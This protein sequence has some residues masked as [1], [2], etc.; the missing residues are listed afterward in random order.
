MATATKTNI[1]QIGSV[2]VPVSDPDKAIEFY[3]GK[4]GCE[5]RADVPFGD[6]YR[7]IEVAPA[8]AATSI[9]LC[10]PREGDS[11]GVQTGI[12]LTTADIDADHAVLKAKGV[13]I[14]DEVSRMGDPVPPLFWLRDQDG[15]TLML[16]ER[17][18]A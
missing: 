7:W 13:D 15:N 16:V 12:G 14:D 11:V 3:A 5:L 1:T 6:G 2:I 17:A 9:A 18:A 4:L 10:P 8:G